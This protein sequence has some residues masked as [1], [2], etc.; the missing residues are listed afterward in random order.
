MYRRVARIWKRGGLFWKS[1]KC[2]NDLD[3][4]FHCSWM[5][6]TRFFW[7]LRL[8]FSESR[9]LRRNWRWFFGRNPNFKGFLLPKSGGL[10]K[11]N[12]TKKQK[13]GLRRNSGWFF[14]PNRESKRLR[15]VV[16]QWGGYFQFFTKNRPQNHQNGA[17]LHTSQ[18]N[19]GCSSP[20]PPPP[21]ATLLLMLINEIECQLFEWRGKNT[22]T[23]PAFK[24][25]ALGFYN[26]GIFFRCTVL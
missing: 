8:N 2:A 3:P 21:L 18:A 24:K 1:E 26:V 13:K 6:F 5:S 7:K 23:T 4:N 15:G 12:K 17:I 16:F 9:G 14:G 19:G 22:F 25:I 20:P 10:Q 11:K